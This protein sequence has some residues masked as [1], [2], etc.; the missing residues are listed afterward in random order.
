MYGLWLGV[1]R[2]ISQLDLELIYKI[3]RAAHGVF[4]T[5]NHDGILQPATFT[6]TTDDAVLEG[7]LAAYS[8]ILSP[9]ALL[10]EAHITYILYETLLG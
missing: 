6:Y 7:G 3:N 9:E 5:N 2:C 8:S 4:L 1:Y 10:F